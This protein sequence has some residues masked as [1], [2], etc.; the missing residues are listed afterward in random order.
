MSMYYV[1]CMH[2]QLSMA[3]HTPVLLAPPA[4]TSINWNILQPLLYRTI[5]TYLLKVLIERSIR[6]FS[7]AADVNTSVRLE[8]RINFNKT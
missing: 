4:R 3:R 6:H 5:Y 8:V 1:R 7:P 2:L